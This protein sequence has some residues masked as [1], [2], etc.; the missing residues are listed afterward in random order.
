MIKRS[1]LKLII[2]SQEPNALCKRVRAA[3]ANLTEYKRFENALGA[4][5][6][7]HG[8]IEDAETHLAWAM[9]INVIQDDK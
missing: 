5:V 6:N 3:A 1:K 4:Y 7:G 9:G 8:P 2:L